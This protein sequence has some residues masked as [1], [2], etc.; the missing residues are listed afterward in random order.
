MKPHDW[1]TL[2]GSVMYTHVPG[3][4]ADT[5][6]FYPIFLGE[7]ICDERYGVDRKSFDNFLLI[8]VKM[9][10]GYAEAG[11]HSYRLVAGDIMLIDCY[12]PHK[13]GTNSSWEIQWIHFDGP[14]AR[15]Y[16]EKICRDSQLIRVANHYPATHSLRKLLKLYRSQ[17]GASDVLLAKWITDLLTDVIMYSAES[18]AIARQAEVIDDCIRY[19]SDNLEKDISVEQL[20]RQT[21]LSPFY[22]SR[23]FKQ[24]TGF[25]PHRY[26]VM[27]RL[28]YSRYVLRTSNLTV[29]ETAYR[30]GF[31]SE[32]NF[33]TRF[34]KAFG[35]TPQ[36]YRM[37]L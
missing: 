25:S 14:M 36:E 28:D 12:L 18:S 9:G 21:M 5:V 24:E 32:S 16:F 7:Y 30:C 33:C 34:R 22:F 29:K 3:P 19:I 23:L 31:N 10:E 27:V 35:I 11:G 2:P 37:S 1:G 26:I 8:Y 6:S 17:K 15:A 20:A 4:G 13:Y